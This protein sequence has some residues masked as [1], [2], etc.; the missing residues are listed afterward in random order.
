M[1]DEISA[2]TDLAIHRVL[3]VTLD[4]AQVVQLTDD[5]GRLRLPINRDIIFE[6]RAETLWRPFTPPPGPWRLTLTM[7]AS[8]RPADE[9]PISLDALHGHCLR[10][11][12]STSG[13]EPTVDLEELV[14]QA[15]LDSDKP[16][17]LDL[18]AAIMRE[19]TPSERYEAM[20]AV[21]SGLLER[22]EG[23]R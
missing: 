8:D 18:A 2:Q 22:I 16:D 20:I 1:S 12:R 9:V 19:P 21:L 3:T 17:E 4:S 11:V 10:P 13:Y 6:L 7:P 15:G 14:D 23:R 5:H